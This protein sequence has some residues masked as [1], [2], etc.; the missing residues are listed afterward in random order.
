MKDVVDVEVIVD[1]HGRPEHAAVG[2]KVIDL[3][4]DVMTQLTRNIGQFKA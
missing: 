4:G 3:W 1:P 2:T